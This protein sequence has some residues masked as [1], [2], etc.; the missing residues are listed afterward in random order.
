MQYTFSSTKYIITVAG[1]ITF[2][3]YIFGNHN[4]YLYL[5]P[6]SIEYLYFLLKIYVCILKLNQ[7]E[8]F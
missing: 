3:I 8:D 5:R 4:S 1:Y 6:D 7:A 2:D